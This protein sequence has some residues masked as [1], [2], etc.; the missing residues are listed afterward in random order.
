MS[1]IF[2]ILPSSINNAK[3][4]YHPLAYEWSFWQHIRLSSLQSSKDEEILTNGE[5]KNEDE[6]D[7]DSQRE[8]NLKLTEEENLEDEEVK[9]N[10]V[11]ATQYLQE[12][13][14][15]KFPKIYSNNN[16]IEQTENIDSVEQ[17][18]ES[19]SNLKSVMDVPID[20]EYF[21][22][23]K[24]IKPLWED[25]HNRKGGRWSLSITNNNKTK[26]LFSCIFWELLLIKLVSGKFLSPDIKLPLSKEILDNEEFDEVKC[27]KELSNEELNKLIMDDIAGLV[28]SVR[29]K[30]IILSIWNTHLSFENYKKENGINGYTK[31]DEYSHLYRERLNSRSKHIYEN[32]GLTTFQFRQL[33][34]D[35]VSKTMNE[36]FELV[37][38][39]ENV[40]DLHR[41]YR[42]QNFKYAPHF[43]GTSNIDNKK[44]KYKTKKNSTSEWHPN[45]K[46]TK[47]HVHEM[48]RFSNLGKLRKKVEFNEEGLMVEELNVMS[49]RNKWNRK[50]RTVSKPEKVSTTGSSSSN[51]NENYN[52]NESENDIDNE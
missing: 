46:N 45:S 22:F 17:F 40:K 24:G 23:K 5:E 51:E 36:A 38:D 33:I 15:L 19:F 10:N 6:D 26:R 42:H 44:N 30:K 21:F 13:T 35:S 12:T 11:R 14:I 18:W 7:N 39:H 3:E 2:D 1:R 48:E 50:R 20:T 37:K 41:A 28:I 32:I 47:S 25:E 34:F 8:S 9:T 29:N 27:K 49:F 52:Y 4:V 16:E 43:N 31:T